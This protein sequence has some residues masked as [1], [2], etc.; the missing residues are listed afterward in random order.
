MPPWSLAIGHLMTLPRL[1][2]RL[3]IGSQQSDAFSLL[4]GEFADTDGCF[5]IDVWAFANPLLVITSPELAVQ[6]CQ[7]HDL[8]KPDV[9]VPFFAPIAGGPNLVDM[10]VTQRKRSRALFS[11][12]FS[13]NVMLECMPHTLGET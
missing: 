6:V 3:P 12:G 10:N 13:A 4:S 7:E 2:D 5:Y 1:L 11:A 9:L 8:P